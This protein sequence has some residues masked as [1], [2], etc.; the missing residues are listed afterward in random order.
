MINSIFNNAIHS[1]EAIDELYGAMGNLYKKIVD[2]KPLSKEEGFEKLYF[3]R[4]NLE[5]KDLQNIITSSLIA[6]NQ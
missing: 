3:V 4:D 2:Y 1:N 5:D 6:V